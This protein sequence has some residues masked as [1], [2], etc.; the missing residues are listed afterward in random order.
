MQNTN[1]I[2]L[3]EY[4]LLFMRLQNPRLPPIPLPQNQLSYIIVLQ[5][6]IEYI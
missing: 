3:P 1:N 6:D 5:D 4:I 2:K